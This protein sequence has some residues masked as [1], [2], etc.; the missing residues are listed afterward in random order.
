MGTYYLPVLWGDFVLLTPTD[1]LTRDDTWISHTDLMNRFAAIPEALPNAELRAQVNNYFDQ[2]L[3]SV[4]GADA[5][6]LIDRRLQP[7]RSPPSAGF[8]N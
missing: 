3:R 1:M 7:P 2:H 5:E 4:R 6:S 8:Q